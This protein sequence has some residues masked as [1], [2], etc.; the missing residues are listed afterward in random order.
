MPLLARPHYYC[1]KFMTVRCNQTCPSRAVRTLLFALL[2]K[3]LNSGPYSNAKQNG[4]KCVPQSPI[5]EQHVPLTDRHSEQNSSN[6]PIWEQC[7]PLTN[8]NSEQISPNLAIQEQCVPFT[9][10]NSEQNSP[11]LPIWEQ[12]VPLTDRNSEQNSPNLPEDEEEEV[13]VQQ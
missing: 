9:D 10:R 13:E 6:L 1:A 5:Q 8:R 11:N 7:V 12:C 4:P 2:K 3:H